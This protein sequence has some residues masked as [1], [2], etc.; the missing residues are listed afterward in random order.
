[1]MSAIDRRDTFGRIQVP[2][3]KIFVMETTAIIVT[4]ADFG[5]LSTEKR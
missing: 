1:M 2:K 4:T 5:A 3:D